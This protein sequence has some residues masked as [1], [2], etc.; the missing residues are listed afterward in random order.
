MPAKKVGKKPR[1]KKVAARKVIVLPPRRDNR[2]RF[3][4]GRYDAAQ[5]GADNRR[6]WSNTDSL[7]AIQA[8]SSA[9]R[10]TLSRRARYEM[11]NNVYAEGI[12]DTLA[13]DVIG[14]GP[15]LKLETGDKELDR[16]LERKFMQWSKA[17]DLPGGLRTMRVARVRDGE[18]FA[19]IIDNPELPGVQLDLRLIEGEQVDTPTL[20]P[21]GW[22]EGI[23]FDKSGN[24]TL[25]SILKHHPGGLI[26]G[27]ESDEIDRA[28]VLHWYKVKRPGQIRGVSELTSSLNLFAQVRRWELAVLGSAETTAELSMVLQTSSSYVGDSTNIENSAFTEVDIERN[29]MTTLPEHW[30]MKQVKP[31][32]PAATHEKFLRTKVNQMGR[33]H[34]MPYNVASADSSE[35][36]FASGRLDHQ[37]YFETIRVDR[38][39]CETHVLDRI[40]V[41]WIREAMIVFGRTAPNDEITHKWLW[42]GRVH[43][44]PVKEAKAQELRLNNLTSTLAIEY[45]REGIDLEDALLQ[46]QKEQQMIRDLGI[47]RPG[48]TAPLSDKE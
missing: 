10:K 20:S 29:T 37:G 43:V 2:G 3:M 22:V 13:T 35:Y 45:A 42:P 24:P 1:A 41:L 9:V 31:E 12:A 34:G 21:S 4:R 39:H 27:G 17:T 18:G 11:E 47:I 6:H 44:D 30:E 46:I 15:R 16:L 25:Y 23:K 19:V 48:A 38:G 26:P 40:L 7:S 14:V 36:N 8:N 5:N 33:P 28:H 32:Q